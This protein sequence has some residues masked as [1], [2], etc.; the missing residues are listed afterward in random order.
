MNSVEFI[1]D[2]IG[3]VGGIGVVGKTTLLRTTDGG[4]TWNDANI[5]TVNDIE[6][7]SFLDDSIGAVTTAVGELFTSRNAGV[8]WQNTSATLGA[9]RVVLHTEKIW[10]AY[11]SNVSQTLKRTTDGGVRWNSVIGLLGIIT[12]M[13]FHDSSSA[14]GFAGTSDGNFYKSIDHGRTWNKLNQPINSAIETIFFINEAHGFL[15]GKRTSGQFTVETLDS[16]KTWTSTVADTGNA[17]IALL[18]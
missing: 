4:T 11:N 8:T 17:V 6:Q 9:N 5:N 13:Y 14:I 16:G 2:N 12:S 7:I 3:F 1:D 18:V 15:S 10:L